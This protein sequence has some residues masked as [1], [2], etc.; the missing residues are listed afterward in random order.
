MMSSSGYGQ[1]RTETGIFDEDPDNNPLH[2]YNKVYLAYCTSDGHMGDIDQ[3]SYHSN[4]TFQFRGRRVIRALVKDVAGQ[5]EDGATVFFG[6]FSA[7]A[8]GAM[9]HLD[10]TKEYIQKNVKDSKVYGII[11]SAAYMDVEP[12][13]LKD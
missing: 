2:D 4:P 8:R 1:T 10:Q 7:G 12:I 11:D 3:P 5:M 13:S 6:G 9:M